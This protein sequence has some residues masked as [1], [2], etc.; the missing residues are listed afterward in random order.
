MRG[1]PTAVKFFHPGVEW[2]SSQDRGI[3]RWN[4]EDHRRKYL[5]TPGTFLSRLEAPAKTGTLGFW[6]EYEAPTLFRRL[7]YKPQRGLP[8]FVHTL[9]PPDPA[10]CPGVE[11]RNTDPLVLSPR[12][13]YTNCQQQSRSRLQHLDRG[14][15]ILFG[16]R[17]EMQFVIDTVFVVDEAIAYSPD[18]AR[19]RLS[20]CIPEWVYPLVLDLETAPVPWT[21]EMC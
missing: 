7:A 20:G 21:P 19:S 12:W 17:V 14:D 5:Q 1:M 2:T 9:L 18:E 6:G 16:S 4:T 10:L 15:V 13:L 11:A 8:R 3:A